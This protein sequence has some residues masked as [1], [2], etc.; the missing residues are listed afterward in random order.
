M[1]TGL[2]I[3]KRQE[4]KN[5]TRGNVL[6]G[7]K[8]RSKYI[9]SVTKEAEEALQTGRKGSHGKEDNQHRLYTPQMIDR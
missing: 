4:K 7:D 8:K 5:K 1:K 3:R 9:K 6:W 2:E